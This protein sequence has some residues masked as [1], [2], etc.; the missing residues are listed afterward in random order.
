MSTETVKMTM[1]MP[2]RN[3]DLARVVGSLASREWRRHWG[4]TS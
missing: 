2:E 1:A 3:D 4:F